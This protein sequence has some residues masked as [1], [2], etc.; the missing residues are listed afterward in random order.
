LGFGTAVLFIVVLGVFFVKKLVRNRFFPE[1][2]GRDRNEAMAELI[3]F[4]AALQQ[5]ADQD[6][7]GEKGPSEFRAGDQEE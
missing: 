7:S 1:D 2:S 3:A 4:Q 5:K 6:S